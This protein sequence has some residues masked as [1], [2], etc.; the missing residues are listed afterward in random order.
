MTILAVTVIGT[1]VG[2]ILAVEAQAKPAPAVAAV[3]PR[4]L[5][6]LWRRMMDH[7]WA[8]VTVSAI[9]LGLSIGMAVVLEILEERE[10]SR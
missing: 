6:P 4:P 8:P 3:V 10:K 7:P 9:G 1:V 5:D 2:T